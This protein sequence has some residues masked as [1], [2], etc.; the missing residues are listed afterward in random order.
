MSTTAFEQMEFDRLADADYRDELRAERSQRALG[1]ERHR[2]AYDN[3][4]R[5]VMEGRDCAFYATNEWRDATDAP[6]WNAEQY[7]PIFAAVQV[8]ASLVGATAEDRW[9]VVVNALR[10]EAEAYAAHVAEEA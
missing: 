10:R 6:K 1:L 5:D 7:V 2:D 8:A 9:N 3:A 4:Y